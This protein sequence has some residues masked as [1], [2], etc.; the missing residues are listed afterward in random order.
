MGLVSHFVTRQSLEV[1]EHE[2]ASGTPLCNFGC[3]ASVLV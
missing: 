2:K 3:A 1:G